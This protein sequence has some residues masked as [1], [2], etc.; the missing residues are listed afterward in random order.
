MC[1]S[2]PPGSLVLGTDLKSTSSLQL[3]QGLSRVQWMHAC[4]ENLSIL[5]N[6]LS[7]AA[8]NRT[9]ACKQ[10]DATT[11]QGGAAAKHQQCRLASQSAM[12]YMCKALSAHGVHAH[13]NLLEQHSTSQP[14]ATSVSQ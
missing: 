12:L 3:A 8:N 9:G 5:V 2:V 6:Q 13:L 7:V 10:S 14:Y 11:C 1:P 4:S